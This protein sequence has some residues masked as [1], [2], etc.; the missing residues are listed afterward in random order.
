MPLGTDSVTAVY[1]ATANFGASTSSAISQVVNVDSTAAAVTSSLNPAA[2]G[3]SVTLTATVASA[4]ASPTGSVVFMDGAT[5]LGTVTLTSSG[6]LTSNATLATTSLPA[7]TDPITVVYAASGNF[8]A[9]TSAALNQVVNAGSTTAAVASSVNPASAGQSVTLT[10]T[11]SSGTAAPTGPVVFMDGATAIGTVTLAPGS[12]LSSTATLTTSTLPI[13]TDAITVVYAA[14]ANFGAATSPALSLVVNPAATAATVASSPNPAGAGQ[15]VTLTATVSSGFAAPTGSVIFKNGST[16]IG[17]GT[18]TP[19]SGL[20][21]TATLTTAALPVGTDSITASYAATGN[22][23]ATVSAALSQVVNAAGTT[24]T[25]ASSASPS[26]EGQSVTFTAT[27]SSGFAAPTGSVVFMNGATSIGSATLTPGSGLSS[28]ATLTI[29]TLPVGTDAITVVYAAT[30][31]FG[32][33]TSTA[34][35]QVVNAAA[36]TAAVASS[37]SPS[38]YSQ[39]V[40]LTA[41]VSSGYA[42]PTGSVTFMSGSTS[43]GSVTLT[44]GSG[45]SST[46]TF[47]T[48]TLPLGSNS[49][50]AVYAAT[51]NFGAATSAAMTQ[52]VNAAGTTAAVASSLNP[53]SSNQPVI[54][55][56]TVSSGFAAPTGS[57]TFM[58][59]STPLGSVTLTPG[60]GP[61]STATLTTSTLPVGTD[62][63]T[64]V[65]AA[66]ANFGASTSA[67]LGQVVNTATSTTAT[68]LSSLNPA[69]IGQPVTLTAALVGLFGAPTGSVSFMDGAATIGT[70]T[71]ASTGGLTS[72]AT[73]TTSTLPLGTDPITVVYAGTQNFGAATSAVLS[74]VVSP[75]STAAT[76]AS[77]L[78]P[79]N[80]GQ[81]VTFTA[82]LSSSYAA[83]I[84]S[85][86]FKNGTTVIGSAILASGGGLS[87]TATLTTSALPAGTDSITAVYAATQNFSGSASAAL[88]QVVNAS[89]TAATV[90]SSLSPASAGQSV[91]LTATLSSST[92]APTGSVVFMNGGTAIGSATLAS[93]GSLTSM[94]TLTTS[95]LPVG[96]DS[97]TAVYAAT[98]SFG[99][100]TS[101][102]LIQVVNLAGSTTTAGSSASPSS[103]GQA[104]TLTATVSGSYAAPTGSVTFTYGG[105]MIG[106][107]TL[108]SAGGLSS[109]ATLI[110]S[111]LPVGSDPITATYVPTG[112]FSASSV[113]LTQVVNGL[114]STA[115]LTASPNPA[116]AGQTVTLTASVTGSSAVPGGTVSFFSGSTLLGSASLNAS[117]IAAYTTSSLAAGGDTLTAVYSGSAIYTGSTSPAVSETIQALSQNFT[118]TLANPNITVQTQNNST[119]S[120]TLTSQNGYADT[121]NLSCANLP[122]YITCVLTPSAATLV[123]NGTT[124]VSLYIDTDSVLGY[125]RNGSGPL[126]NGSSPLNLALMLSPMGL[127]AGILAFP[128][129]RS[130]RRTRLYL[131]ILFLAAIPMTLAFSGCGNPAATPN[132]TP[133][134]APA[135]TYTIPITATGASSGTSHTVQL[136]LTVTP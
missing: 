98:P 129:G 99:A 57:V 63:I 133:P 91:T 130:R 68:A 34:F 134:S 90:A 28:T 79:A 12:G 47:A 72:A 1:A 67:A 121:L 123:A 127:F 38:S 77:S 15:S 21:S 95:A 20:S 76:I 65:Y 110:A 41:S 135:G 113:S 124:A 30:A 2:A 94:A 112:S 71:L 48:S 89:G 85:V 22:F 27:V 96:S 100:A 126:G 7:G 132:V 39:S 116:A 26:S 32:A 36:T 102:V 55:T 46:A 33:S 88:S 66:T 52:V 16:L 87:S 62:P 24:A 109:T 59:G 10:A 128:M 125:A 4:Y 81:S 42:A 11:V 111:N 56:A 104:V 29:S 3:Q 25:V 92:A 18:L 70:G 115:T 80:A 19:G 6:S 117:G 23:A 82:T 86:I 83:P 93:T 13:G 45:L 58:N 74:Q 106:T 84:G 44:P 37:L 131:L 53:S 49:I 17:S 114:L 64:V 103:F 51:P 9:T 136:T 61:S 54:L 119:S 31:N 75:A 118:M 108:S 101:P 60:S 43:L 120:V 107:A 40:T 105:S 35:N 97:I 78:N 14:T 8:G 69:T 5:A 122:T 73:L 50:T